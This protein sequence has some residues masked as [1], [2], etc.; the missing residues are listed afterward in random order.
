MFSLNSK[1]G[2][3]KVY[4]ETI[5]NEAISQITELA[6]SPVG[7]NAHIRIMPD[8]H[9]GTGCVIGTTMKITDKVCPN[10]V[11]VDIGCGVAA[12][13]IRGKLTEEDYKILDEY[14]KNYVYSGMSIRSKKIE[15]FPLETLRCYSEL[16][17]VDRLEKSLGTLGSGNHFIELDKNNLG[18]H[19]LVVHTGSRN[20]GKQVAEFYQNLAVKQLDLEYI[21]ARQKVIDECKAC[22]RL[23]LIQEKLEKLQKKPKTGLEYLTGK[24]FEH[25]IH[26]MKICQEWAALNRYIIIR[27]ILNDLGWHCCWWTETIHN[28]IDTKTMILRKGSVC[29]DLNKEFLI[30]LNMRDGTLICR[31]KGNPDWNNSAPHGAGRLMSRSKAKET[32]ELEDF[33][34]S[35]K[36]IVSSTVCQSTIDESPFAYKDCFEIIETIKPTAD[37]IGIMKPVFNYKATE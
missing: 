13:K 7:E 11:G 16:K 21:N 12:A 18:A 3:V 25:Y 37:I 26:D 32:I 6:N 10:L 36:G 31:G 15:N 28:Y 19:F 24:N 29:A 1:Y 14:C 27:E 30:P 35:M 20:L 23:D 34:R 22:N 4:A 33:E 2:E 5:E 9:A 8:A 17:N